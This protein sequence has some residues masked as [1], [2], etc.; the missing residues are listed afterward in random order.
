LPNYKC[1]PCRQSKGRSILYLFATLSSSDLL[2]LFGVIVNGL[3]ADSA[4]Q[5]RAL[6]G[7]IEAAAS[8]AAK[9][10]GE[11]GSPFTP[12]WAT[13]KDGLLTYVRGKK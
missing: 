5:Q 2:L 3:F 8:N 11:D 12:L 10:E 4:N 13:E 7:E 1:S 6:Q 9:E